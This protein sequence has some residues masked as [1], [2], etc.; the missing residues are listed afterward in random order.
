M[1]K[2]YDMGK[3]I[4]I[5]IHEILTLSVP[6]CGPLHC[7][8]RSFTP[9][10]RGPPTRSRPS[11][12]CN[13]PGLTSSLIRPLVYMYTKPQPTL[14]GSRLFPSMWSTLKEPPK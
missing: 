2:T 5:Y 10:I 13:L 11:A 3:E 12:I 8:P 7:I 1:R 4:N 6:V 14:T 9:T